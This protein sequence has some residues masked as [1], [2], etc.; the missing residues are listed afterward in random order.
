[1][2]VGYYPVCSV[3]R[4]QTV[5]LQWT[6]TDNRP[7]Y[8]VKVHTVGVVGSSH[9]HE[10]DDGASLSAISSAR[11]STHAL[12][13]PPCSATVMLADLAMPGSVSD[14]ANTD[15]PVHQG[16]MLE[17]VSVLCALWT[18]YAR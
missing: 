8:V 5:G 9:I 10:T 14:Q 3:L 2:N 17:H 11:C 18:Y 15:Q 16:T 12:H 7:R 13:S 4:N 6:T 1:M